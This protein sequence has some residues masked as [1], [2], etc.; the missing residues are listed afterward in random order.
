MYKR[1]PKHRIGVNPLNKRLPHMVYNLEDIESIDR[2]KR[3]P[4]NFRDKLAKKSVNVM[5]FFFDSATRYNEKKMT[6]E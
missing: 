1:L 2:T 3:E 5:R 6:K 4:L